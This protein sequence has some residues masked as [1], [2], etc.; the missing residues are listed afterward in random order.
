MALYK[1]PCVHCG[2]F[3]ERDARFCPFC[4]SGSPF[5]YHCPTCLR[6]VE[7]GQPICSGCGRVLFVPC[8]ACGKPTFAAE[9]CAHCGASL[10]KRCQNPRCGELQFFDNEKCTACGKKF[11]QK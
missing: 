2:A 10:M 11:K 7:K 8:P 9:K 3:I 4:Q 1:L 6:P 5:G